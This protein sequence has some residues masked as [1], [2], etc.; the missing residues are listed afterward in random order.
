[1]GGISCGWQID[2]QWTH[3]KHLKVS[4]K[5]RQIFAP[6]PHTCR[7]C[8]LDWDFDLPLAAHKKSQHLPGDNRKQTGSQQKFHSI[9][10]R[11]KSSAR[12]YNAN[13]HNFAALE[14]LRGLSNYMLDKGGKSEVWK[15]I[16]TQP[17]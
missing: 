17:V 12:T 10:K 15:F 14:K 8:R 3:R 2:L 11:T 1:M 9:S 7:R 6:A 16:E 5:D 4:L 13:S